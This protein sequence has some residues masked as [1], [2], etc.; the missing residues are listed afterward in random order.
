MTNNEISNN[1]SWNNIFSYYSVLKK[2]EDNTF[3]DISSDQIKQIDGKEARLMAKIDY[4]EHLPTVMKEN[5]LSI[6]AIKNGLYRIAKV[7]PFISIPSQPKN[8]ISLPAPENLFSIN[9]FE[10]KSESNA[11]DIAFLS[12][13]QNILFKETSHLTIRG[14][15]RA[16]LIFDI[17]EINYEVE[18]V[19]IEVD[20]GYESTS[21]IFLIEAK[22][23]Y[24]GNINVRQLL[25][26]QLY[27]Q[28]KVKEKNI[29]TFLFIHQENLF[30][31]IP[32]FYEKNKTGF[33]NEKQEICF[34]FNEIQKKSF[35][36]RSIQ[37]DYSDSLVD[38]NIPF[39][40][41]DNFERIISILNFLYCS[42]EGLTKQ[43]IYENFDLVER[44]IDYYLNALKWL[45]LITTNEN[46]IRITLIGET[47]SALPF[48]VK[49]Q[50]IA[51][52][53]YSNKIFN[54]ILNKKEIPKKWFLEY[55]MLS[56]N[57]QRR[58]LTTVQSWICYFLLVFP[59]NE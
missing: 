59:E 32:Y 19:Q 23:G 27:W 47:I 29:Q 58:R 49:M 51:N 25:Y 37:I 15:E 53:I 36:I 24:R 1:E 43:K 40:Q 12:G 33:L 55:K 9:P 44:Q 46:L 39:P 54:F 2:I 10:I 14:R 57:T 20:S 42:K 17:D 41:A 6:L 26:P 18:G 21:S 22:L 16:N 56:E 38:I 11:L 45:K 50:Q 35:N 34:K 7:N 8:I 3:F 52:I 5:N 30:R 31:F 48:Q 4:Y 13:M 28:K